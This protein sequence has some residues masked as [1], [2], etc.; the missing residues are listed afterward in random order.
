[1]PAL[2]EGFDIDYTKPLNGTMA[3]YAEQVIVCTGQPDWPSNIVEERNGDNVAADLREL[4]GP[5]GKYS[6]PFHNISVTNSSLPSSN[7]ARDEVQT[8]SAFL[9]PSFKYIPFLPRV[10]FDSV[11]ALVKGYL[12]P[13][14]LHSAHDSLSPIHRDRLTRKKEFQELLYGAQD[15]QDILVLICGHGGRDIRCGIL[16]PLLQAEFEKQLPDNGIEVAREPIRIPSAS[17]DTAKAIGT[18]APS[19]QTLTARVGLIS[20]IGGHKFAGNTVIYIPKAA[21]TADGA[22]HPLAG[23]GIWYGRMQPGHVQGTIRETILHG[24]I[25]VDMFRGGVREGGQ[26]LRLASPCER[27]VAHP[28]A[29]HPTDYWLNQACWLQALRFIVGFVEIDIDSNRAGLNDV[30]AFM[31][32]D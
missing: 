7:S 28:Q 24:R 17:S 9:F 18:D 8:T 11:E 27:A 19:P 13:T 29:P 30:A 5:R 14:K 23:S 25:I 31:A 12:L 10:S 16:G 21:R 26:I 3:P 15:V 4:I 1:M 22:P 2:P 20:H 6:D 32:Q